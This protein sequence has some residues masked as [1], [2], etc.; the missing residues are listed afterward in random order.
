MDAHIAALK[1]ALREAQSAVNDAVGACQHEKEPYEPYDPTD[2]W[3][4]SGIICRKCDTH[5]H[6]WYC[7][8]SPDKACE[9]PI[10]QGSAS[11][12]CIYCHQPSERK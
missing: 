4:S 3:F 12:Y 2:K 6:G 7:H 9:Y 5:F 11:E 10:G 1:Q 8:T